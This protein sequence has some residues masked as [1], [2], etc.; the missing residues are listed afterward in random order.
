VGGAQP[1]KEWVQGAALRFFFDDFLSIFGKNVLVLKDRILGKQEFP[2]TGSYVT[3]RPDCSGPSRREVKIDV[4]KYLQTI[5]M[6]LYAVS[7]QK[8]AHPDRVL[9]LRLGKPCCEAG[10]VTYQDRRSTF[11]DSKRNAIRRGAAENEVPKHQEKL[12]C[13]GRQIS[14]P[15]RRYEKWCRGDD[16][17]HKRLY[18]QATI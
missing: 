6:G 1:H 15:R 2:K 3:G 9:S 5:V 13:A 18:T 12:T 7:E 17:G 14:T 11:N 10:K 4:W 16:M 8:L